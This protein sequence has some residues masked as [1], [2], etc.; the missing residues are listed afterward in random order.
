MHLVLLFLCAHYVWQIFSLIFIFLIKLHLNE[1]IWEE[2]TL[3]QYC[4]IVVN[5]ILS[6]VVQNLCI[7]RLELPVREAGVELIV[8]VSTTECSDSIVSVNTT[9][10]FNNHGSTDSLACI[11]TSSVR[12]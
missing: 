10:T 6:N 5:I 12:E 9:T 1:I 11:W 8:R 7:L 3:I 4:L 2:A